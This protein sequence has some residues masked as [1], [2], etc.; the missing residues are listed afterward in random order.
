M[1][2][3][4]IDFVLNDLRQKHLD[5]VIRNIHEIGVTNKSYE[6]HPADV[7]WNLCLKADPKRN[8]RVY[9]LKDIK[10]QEILII[11]KTE[12][13]RFKDNLNNYKLLLDLGN[14]INIYGRADLF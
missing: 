4:N 13:E 3:N 7:I 9:E 10:T 5:P 2:I 1:Y 14:R 6:F 8:V 11:D 12:V